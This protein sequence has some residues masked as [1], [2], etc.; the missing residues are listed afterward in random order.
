VKRGV[1][2]ILDLLAAHSIPATFYVPGYTAE[3]HPGII[4]SIADA[5]H[6]I[7]HHGYLHLRSNEIGAKEQREEIL[8]GTDALVNC[9]GYAPPGYR[10]PTWELTPETFGL[11]V[12]RGFRFDSSCMGDDRPYFETHAGKSILE[13]PVSRSL[14]DWPYYWFTSGSGGFFADMNMVLDVWTQEFLAASQERR[15]VTYTMHP[16]IIG[17]PYRF[18]ILEKLIETAASTTGVWFA[19]HSMVADI[20][21]SSLEDCGATIAQHEHQ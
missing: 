11:I 8:R 4:R 14:D 7:G 15:S 13:L 5:G 10:S 2:R 17:R 9:I 3:K 20:A 16:E 19:T 21:L 6:E 1:P 18:G 12:E